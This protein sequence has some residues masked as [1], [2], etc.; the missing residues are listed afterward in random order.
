MTTKPSIKQRMDTLWRDR[1]SSVILAIL[2]LAIIVVYGIMFLKSRA[3]AARADGM[4]HQV[5]KILLARKGQIPQFPMFGGTAG[6]FHR[7]NFRAMTP[8]QRGAF[9]MKHR[10]AME[11]F[12]LAFA[13]ANPRQRQVIINA[14][15]A[16]FAMMRNHHPRGG[17]HG[18][19]GR[20]NFASRMPQMM[21]N[22]L[23]RGNPQMHA[24]MIQFF[25][26]LHGSPTTR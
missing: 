25:M 19:G 1:R 18:P 23:I 15:K 22:G 26:G 8:A 14:A 20:G 12:F 13:H 7:P 24:A 3:N 11:A 21:A 10:A 16:H 2:V 5:T 17:H 9:F 6:H 4:S